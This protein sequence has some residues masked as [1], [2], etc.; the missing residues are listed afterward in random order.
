MLYRGHTDL[1]TTA[2]ACNIAKRI[3]L[4]LLIEYQR[5]FGEIALRKSSGQVLAIGLH[6]F[7]HFYIFSPF[8][9]HCRLFPLVKFVFQVVGIL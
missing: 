3:K 8:L 6:I 7:H 4:E 5:L 2:T 9:L 1:Q